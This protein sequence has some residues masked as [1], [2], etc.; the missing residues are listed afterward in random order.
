MKVHGDAFGDDCG[1]R[2]AERRGDQRK[3][4]HQARKNLS[5]TRA[6][7]SPTTVCRGTIAVCLAL[8]FLLPGPVRSQFTDQTA[9]AGVAFYY[10]SSGQEK[11]HIVE[12]IGGGAAFFDYDN[13]GDL[14]IYAV[15]GST[16]DTYRQKS[17]PGNVLYRNN[18]NGTF[19]DV[20]ISAR[21]GDSG[22][23]MGC[24]AG[25]IDGDG[26]IDLYV[27]NYGPNI[28]YRNQGRGSFD[29]IAAT[30]GVAGDDY[31]ASAA[32][33]DYDNDGDL[34]L[35]VTTYLVY[36]LDSPPKK[37][38]TYGGFEI[39]CGPQGLPRGGDVLYRNDGDHLFADV[40]Q[41][42]GISWA[43]RY[44][45]LGVVPADFDNDGDTDLFVANDKTPNLIF[46][47]NGNGTFTETGLQA[48]VAYNALGEEEA[49]MGIGAG[50]YDGDGD[51]DLYVTHFFR[52]SNT[53]YRNDGQGRFEDIT[54]QV[55]LEAPTL[56]KLGW[57]T[58]FF[59]YDNDADL[60]LFVANGHVYP[61]VDLERMGTS[62]RQRNQL[63]RHDG[64]GR[65]VELS[66]EAGPGMAIEKVSRGAAF[67]DY[68]NDGDIDIF[69]VNQ[70]D[71]AT[72]LRNDT[73]KRNWLVVQLFGRGNRDAVGARIRLLAGGKVQW[74]TVNGAYSYLSY[75]DIRA[76]FGLGQRLQ[77]DLVEVT[78]PD[79][80]QQA[81][82]AV[83]ANKLLVV[84]QHN[85]HVVLELG[86]NPHRE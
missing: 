24:T 7:D 17:G 80:T 82:R 14:D 81:V 37:I 85:G 41:S 29:D 34:D 73:A 18:G 51:I 58:Q 13:D 74:Q 56:G 77:A 79:G 19:V 16:V 27:T 3:S 45:G 15:N 32:F 25:D 76:H 23:G 31:S 11:N 65:L 55:G 78:W 86:E 30:A 49:G 60:D 48:G 72:L 39:Y 54:S 59:D 47:N 28:L 53:L 1:R 33:F 22:W 57:G 4:G 40:T 69:V 9:A 12:S 44:Y 67:G 83:P 36:D 38:C 10:V 42:S 43:N 63:F 26:F 61:S 70:D 35:Y 84:R 50:D 20:T 52:E 2:V 21:V 71:T 5:H 62:Y 8:S 64:D 46:R 66:A 6:Q 68:D 75:N